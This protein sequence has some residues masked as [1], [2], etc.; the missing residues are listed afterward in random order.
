MRCAAAGATRPLAVFRRGRAG[1]SIRPKRDSAVASPLLRQWPRVVSRRRRAC[2]A[3][4]GDR[5][6]GRKRRVFLRLDSEFHGWLGLGFPSQRPIRRRPW[7]QLADRPGFARPCQ[8]ADGWSGVG[9]N[10]WRPYHRRGPGPLG[11]VAVR[12]SNGRGWFC[13]NY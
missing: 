11:V 9:P 7:C 2:A 8:L 1:P 6:R 5:L 3:D 10:R 13:P 4:S 12:L